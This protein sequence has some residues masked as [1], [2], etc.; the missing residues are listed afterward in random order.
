VLGLYSERV[1]FG[2]QLADSIQSVFEVEV[3]CV[4][5][6]HPP[7]VKGRRV[8]Q[9]VYFFRELVLFFHSDGVGCKELV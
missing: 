6:V 1:N 9:V 4:C 2:R 3:V 7:G 5:V 8:I